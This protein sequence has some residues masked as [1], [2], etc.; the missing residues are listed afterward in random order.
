MITQLHYQDALRKIY[1]DTI[2]ITESVQLFVPFLFF[3]ELALKSIT[4][5][6]SFLQ[7][8]GVQ[9]ASLDKVE[10]AVSGIVKSTGSLLK[11]SAYNASVPESKDKVEVFKLFSCYDREKV[12]VRFIEVY[13]CNLNDWSRGL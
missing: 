13:F 12:G 6:A 4:N 2:A 7:E 5:M 9:N 11:A 8:G 10:D 3:Q 1:I